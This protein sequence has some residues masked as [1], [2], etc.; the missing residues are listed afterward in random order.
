[1]DQHTPSGEFDK[2]IPPQYRDLPADIVEDLWPE[3]YYA[4]AAVNAL[5]K[6]RRTKALEAL[7]RKEQSGNGS[8]L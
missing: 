4:D 7:R 8:P 6:E 5:A 2:D 1:M 3:K